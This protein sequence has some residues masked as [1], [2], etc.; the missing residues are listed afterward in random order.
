MSFVDI[1]DDD[2][3]DEQCEEGT[4]YFCGACTL[5]GFDVCTMCSYDLFD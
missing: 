3:D 4:C 5:F 2:S 1:E